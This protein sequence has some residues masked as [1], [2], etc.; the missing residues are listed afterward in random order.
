MCW[1]V[2]VITG[3]PWLVYSVVCCPVLCGVCCYAAAVDGC[4]DNAEK[5]DEEVTERLVSF[6]PCAGMYHI[7]CWTRPWS[8]D[9]TTYR[10]VTGRTATMEE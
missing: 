3:I 4:G 7:N 10:V 8:Q 5:T 6:W 2:N 9:P 1:P